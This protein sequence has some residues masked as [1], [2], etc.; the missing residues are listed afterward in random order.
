MSSLKNMNESICGHTHIS[1]YE[2]QSYTFYHT[3]LLLA[4]QLT[5]IWII[6][7]NKNKIKAN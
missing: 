7:A 3:Y 5:S 2:M 6:F 1:S 4:E